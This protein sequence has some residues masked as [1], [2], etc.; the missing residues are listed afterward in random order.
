MATEVLVPNV[1]EMSVLDL[2]GDT[3]HMWDRSKPA[4]VDAARE[5]FEALKKKGYMIY[6]AEGR[7]GTQGEILQ[8][9]DAAAERII[10]VPRMI[11]G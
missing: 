1:G 8:K 2:S 6:R 7:E 10:A 5:V 3:K 9:F 4:E 11:G